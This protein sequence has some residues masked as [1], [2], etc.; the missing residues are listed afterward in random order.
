MLGRA[1]GWGEGCDLFIV[2]KG[3]QKEGGQERREERKGVGSGEQ[4]EGEGREGI[5]T[6]HQV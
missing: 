2:V 6:T 4:R 1:G 3:G 5:Y